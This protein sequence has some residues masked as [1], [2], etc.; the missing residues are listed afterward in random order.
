MMAFGR[1]LAIG[2]LALL[3]A[4]AASAQ[5]NLDSGKSPAQLYASD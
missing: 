3:F 2:A 5:E 1:G 4:G